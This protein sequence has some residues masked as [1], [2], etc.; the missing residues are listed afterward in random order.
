MD[1]V[2]P[3]IEAN[4][5]QLASIV[6]G[7]TRRRDWVEIAACIE[8]AAMRFPGPLEPPCLRTVK[9][10]SRLVA[11]QGDE[12]IYDALENVVNGVD[13][14][15]VSGVYVADYFP[16]SK[17]VIRALNRV[18]CPYSARYGQWA[19]PHLMMPNGGIIPATWRAA[20]RIF[21]GNPV[22]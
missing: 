5:R 18:K 13:V 12:Y 15:A 10:A 19:Y 17:E 2:T 9:G 20:Y 22:S 16:L 14:G 1:E 4:C 6:L 11:Y 21:L 7:A 3:S 8:L